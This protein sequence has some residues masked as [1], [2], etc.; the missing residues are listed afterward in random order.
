MEKRY[1]EASERPPSYEEE[2]YSKGLSREDTLERQ[3]RRI[4]D[5]YSREEWDYFEYGIKILITLLPADVRCQFT[6]LDHN[7]SPP[8]IE[9]HYQQFTSIQEKLESDTNMIWKKKFIKTFE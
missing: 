1:R 2:T 6:P 8:G 4:T 3:I 9:K 5:Y 7:T